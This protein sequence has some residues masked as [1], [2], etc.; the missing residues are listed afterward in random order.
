M[1]L[2]GAATLTIAHALV[3]ATVP[4]NMAPHRQA[5]ATVLLAIS[6]VTTTKAAPPSMA[7]QSGNFRLSMR[8]RPRAIS[9]RAT[10]A[11]DEQV[12][13]AVTK[14]AAAAGDLGYG[15]HRCQSSSR[16]AMKA[17][18]DR[19]ITHRH[20]LNSSLLLANGHEPIW[21]TRRVRVQQ[22]SVGK[23]GKGPGAAVLT[24]AQATG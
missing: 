6:A 20:E 9:H 16:H 17:L 13:D 24:V 1:L 2:A 18:R 11:S 14:A 12:L 23:R 21:G 15:W 22:Q 3:V 8:D 19:R 5:T 10:P 7:R 4:Q